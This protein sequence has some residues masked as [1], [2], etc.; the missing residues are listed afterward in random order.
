MKRLIL[1]TALSA[2]ATIIAP[3]ADAAINSPEARGYYE[4]GIAMYLNRNY[5]GCI[6]QLLQIRNLSSADANSEDVLFYIAMATLHSGDDEAID[7]L[8]AF[9]RRFPASPRTQDV[10]T[11]IGDYFFTRGSYGEAIDQYAKVDIDALT[12]DRAEDL[13]Y[14]KFYSHLMLGENDRALSILELLKPMR[15][16][17]NAALFYQGYIAYSRQDYR[18]A[19]KL[20]EE[21]DPN[22]EPGDAAAYYL[23]QLD[24]YDGKY[25]QAA[26]Q[27]KTLLSRP[28]LKR[29]APELKRILGESLYATGQRKEALPYLREYISEERTPRPSACYILG[30]DQYDN[31]KYMQAIETLQKAVGT[32][33]VVGQ[34]AYLYLGKSYIKVG[35]TNAAILAFEKASRMDFSPAVSETAGYNYIAAR[36]DGGRVPFGSSVDML[37]NFL[38]KYPDS[39]YADNVRENLVSGYLSDNDCDNALRVLNSVRNPSPALIAAK[40]QVLLMIGAKTYRNGDPEKALSYFTEGEAISNGNAEVRRQCTLWAANCLYDMERYDEAAANY[41]TFLEQAPKSDTNRLSAY[42]NLGYTR[43][44]QQRYEDAFKDFKRVADSRDADARLRADALNRAGDALYCR[45]KFTEASTYYDKAYKTYPDAGDYALFQ[46]AEMSGY[47][48]KYND[49]IATLDQMLERFPSSALVPEALMAKAESLSVIGEG[50][51]AA[52]LYRDIMDKYPTTAQ[53]RRSALMLAMTL[54]NNGNR[55]QAIAAY[56]NVAETYPTSQEARVALDDLRS[57]YAADGKLPE[58]VAFVNSIPEANKIDM[59]DLETTA[60]TSAEDALADNQSTD[61]LIDYLKQYPAG[62]HVPDALLLL[63]QDAAD[64]DNPEMAESYASRIIDQ[65]PDSPQKEDALL[66]RAESEASQGKGEMALDSYAIL[67]QAASTPQMLYDARMGLL[68]T[69]IELGRPAQAL[70]A[71]DQLL[72]SSASG[73]DRDQIEFYRAIALDESGR[74]EEAWDIWTRL[75]ADPATLYGSKSAVS[76][77]ESLT[78]ANQLQRAEKAAN[79]FIDAGSPHNYWYARGFIAYSDLLRLQDK[80]F[81]ADEYLKAL[82]SNYPGTEADIFEMIDSRLDK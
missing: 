75:S 49:R 36:L 52:K 43:L 54:L 69:A 51:N 38:K 2:S 20:F 16:Y 64:R 82:R 67:S 53:G 21:V 72:A 30:V 66:I 5:N 41:L 39:Q 25:G 50:G 46:K 48:R 70:Q 9:L 47:D 65:Y 57:L 32:T 56:K 76:L 74:S 44:R 58:Y 12:A 1:L 68:T 73:V 8:N 71:A 19:R 27:A 81:E 62:A 34:S 31:G 11:S 77:I 61:R 13:L 22:R 28:A 26:Q 80:T 29:F 78:K 18:Q 17:G 60:F 14:R 79:D 7:L 23:C 24:F 37:E 59:S 63:A 35:N 15:R 42:Y 10:M 45:H 3:S 40:Q 4:R 55:P 33:D 6:D